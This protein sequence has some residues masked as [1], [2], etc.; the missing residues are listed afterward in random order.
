MSVA[1]S[2][3]TV[4]LLLPHL[5][6][7]SGLPNAL[8]RYE[9]QLRAALEA[10][11]IIRQPE[12]LAHARRLGNVMREVLEGWKRQWPLVGDV[13]GLGPM[14]LVELVS[15]PQTKQPLAPA[16]A[17]RIRSQAALGDDDRRPSRR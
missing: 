13:R 11:K 17:L 3:E 7:L 1:H 15:D 6:S 9:P 12:F 2:K 10:L 5:N 14:M 16:D 8:M 4:A